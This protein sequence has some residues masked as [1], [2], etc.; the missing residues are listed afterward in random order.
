MRD[1]NLMFSELAQYTRL[2][3]ETAAIIEGIKDEIKAVMLETG[4]DTITGTE[5]KATYKDVTQSRLDSKALKAEHPD[6]FET[7]NK[8]TTYKR[9]TFA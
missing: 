5:H 2:Q 3:E 6:I 9:F 4:Q 8:A 7:Y 1:V